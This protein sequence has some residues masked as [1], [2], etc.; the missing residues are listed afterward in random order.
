VR[1]LHGVSIAFGGR[2]FTAVMGP[3]GSGKHVFDL[4]SHLD[5]ELHNRM[6]RIG[7]WLDT[8]DMT[9]AETVDA[10]IE[11]LDDP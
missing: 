6:P 11:Q 7:L 8:S 3:S 9:E 4:W 5:D 10:I 2:T 1:A